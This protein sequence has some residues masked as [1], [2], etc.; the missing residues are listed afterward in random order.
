MRVLATTGILLSSVHQGSIGAIFL[1]LS[2]RL[3]ELWWTTI[4]PLL[5]LTSA[6]F[7]GLSVAILLAIL[8]WRALKRP[9]R[10]KL[11]SGLAKVA[12]IP[13]AVYFVLK[14]GNL[15][16]SGEI[17]LVLG[18][19]WLSVLFLAEMIIGVIAPMVMFASPARE[20]ER[21]LLV[22]AAY[23]VTI[24]TNGDFSPS[25]GSRWVKCRCLNEVKRLQHLR[26]ELSVA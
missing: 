2:T 19:G 21:G 26:G 6:L 20:S 5:F 17:G 24:P 7:S 12:A 10:I 13:P 15:L 22:G 25:Q 16:V 9:V 14:L 3:H 8:T 1:L 18:S 23:A 4:L 11:L